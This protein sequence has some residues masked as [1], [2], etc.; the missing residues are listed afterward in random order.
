MRAT[1]SRLYKDLLHNPEGSPRG[2]GGVRKMAVGERR[3]RAPAVESAPGKEGPPPPGR[4]WGPLHPSQPPGPCDAGPSRALRVTRLCDSRL[5]SPPL[6]FF[7]PGH[8]GKA[9]PPPQCRGARRGG[10]LRPA[11]QWQEC[12]RNVSGGGR[13][14]AGPSPPRGGLHVL[15]CWGMGPPTTYSTTPTDSQGGSAAPW[16]AGVPLTPAP[17]C[18]RAAG[19]GKEVA[20]GRGDC[21][22]CLSRWGWAGA[23]RAAAPSRL[24]CPRAGVAQVGRDHRDR[25]PRRA[26]APWWRGRAGRAVLASLAGH[27]C[28]PAPR[29][30]PQEPRGGLGV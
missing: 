15:A 28:P 12:G 1:A 3:K 2:W 5:S 18:P 29:P 10:S 8:P 22:L 26:W 14:P 24:L 9:Q 13:A 21:P 30:G 17:R 6:P 23:W 25:G 7:L 20:G 16:G 4:A 19:R 11:S 27:R